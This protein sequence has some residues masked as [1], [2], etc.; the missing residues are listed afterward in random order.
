MAKKCSQCSRNKWGV[1]S[2]ASLTQ[3][4]TVIQANESHSIFYKIGRKKTKAKKWLWFIMGMGT[5]FSN[6]FLY[7]SELQKYD[8]LTL[9]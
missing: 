2:E 4:V 6:L 3:N 5:I 8:K 9:K 1:H 7:A